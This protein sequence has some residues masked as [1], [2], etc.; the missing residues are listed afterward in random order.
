[1]D[2]PGGRSVY[3]I[4]VKRVGGF[5]YAAALD[6]FGSRNIVQPAV[7]KV[8]AAVL[9]RLK[10]L[11]FSENNQNPYRQALPFEPNGRARSGQLGN[12]LQADGQLT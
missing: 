4:T 5:V 3:L 9:K 11:V 8:G 10:L 2:G 7:S 1:M 12:S 6:G